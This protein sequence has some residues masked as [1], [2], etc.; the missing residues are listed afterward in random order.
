MTY[1][2]GFVVAVPAANKDAYVKHAS[3][4]EALFKEFGVT[5]MVEA[6]GEDICRAPAFLLP[7]ETP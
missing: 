2:E 3:D 7:S 1:V 4:A 5:R 6:W